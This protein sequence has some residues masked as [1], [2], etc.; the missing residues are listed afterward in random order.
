MIIVACPGQGA[1]TPGFLSPWLELPEAREFLAELSDRV[2][3]DLIHFGTEAD[4][5][6]IR[7][8][9]IAQ[10][11][12]VA[13]ELMSWRLLHARISVD[14]L[15]VSGHSV[16]EF[17][18][19]AIAGVLSNEDALE[20][21]SARGAAMAAAAALVPTGMSAVIGGDEGEVLAAIEASGLEPANRNGSGQ[22]VAAG[23]LDALAALAATPPAGARV[24]PLQVAGAFHTSFM[25]PAVATLVDAF[26]SK[27]VH[28][29]TIRLYTNHDGSSVS[30]GETYASLLVSQV[31][32]PVRWDACMESF[33]RDGITAFVELLPGGTLTGIAKRALKGVPSVA[34]KTPAD[35]DAA[36]DLITEHGGAL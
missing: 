12:I 25:E 30:S 35:L 21:V 7:D 22:I 29:P 4:A 9:A 10:P 33:S 18:A 27:P 34:L 17:A 15:A 24:I 36:V 5:D 1:Q 6:A 3:I 11:L 19:A 32:Q 13:A 23:E 26:A 31:S 28:D 16:G 20:L 14:Q 8:T 2:G